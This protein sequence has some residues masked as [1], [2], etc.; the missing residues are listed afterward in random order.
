MLTFGYQLLPKLTMITSNDQPLTKMNSDYHH[1]A[2]LSAGQSDQW[3]PTMTTSYRSWSQ[4]TNND[5]FLPK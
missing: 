1:L 2:K 3:I 4:V 5:N